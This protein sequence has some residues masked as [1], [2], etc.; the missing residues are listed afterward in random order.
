MYISK[1][2][3]EHVRCFDHEEVVLGENH[4]SL[5]IAGNNGTGKSAILRSIAMG[6][7]DEASAGG[8]LRE[9]PGDFIREGEKE[10]T[11]T[12]EF[13]ENNGEKWFIQTIL[14]LYDKLNFERV[15][16]KY[17]KDKVDKINEV[18]DWK[19]FPWEKIFVAGYGAGLRTDGTEDYNQYFSGDAVYTL[20]K[21]SQTLQNPEL[22]WRRLESAAKTN[23]EKNSIKK[24]IS[25]I[26]HDV[27]D[28]A[29]GSN[30]MLK[31]NGIFITKG[32]NDSEMVELGSVGDGYRAITTVILDI[33]S[34]Q[35]LMQNKDKGAGADENWKQ[36]SL[37]DITGIVIIDEVEKHLHPVLQQQ[38]IKHLHDKFSGIQ[39]IISTH[40]P[41]CVSG[42][43]D[44]GSYEEPRYKIYCSYSK[45]KMS[46]GLEE[47]EIPRGLRYDQILVDYFKLPSTINIS[48][49]IQVDR[50]R[51]L[52]LK[53]DPSPDEEAELARLDRELK[54]YA[55]L[56]AEREEDRAA[57]KR[58]R[59]ITEELRRQLIKDGLL[60]DTDTK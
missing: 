46:S 16:Q 59:E 53:D 24:S 44:I 39:F 14:S 11:I 38:I 26:L 56:L 17:F 7:C 12:I 23:E 41:L 13:S 8:L 52:F 57:E 1:I 32:V 29:D 31:P 5:L 33:L 58:T 42:T 28:L 6:L 36:L 18:K 30:V 49:Q 34:W 22:A 3:L 19:L 10:A 27:L 40:S 45:D 37:S 54:R 20:F 50:M 60:D 25:A 51:E 43:A 55:P 2:I 21:Y 15:H 48:L 35:F 9:L 47:N 4:S